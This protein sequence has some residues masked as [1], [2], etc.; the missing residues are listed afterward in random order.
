M[1]RER[2]RNEIL[3]RQRTMKRF[4]T[5]ARSSRRNFY[6]ILKEAHQDGATPTEL[7]KLIKLSVQRA[8]QIVYEKEDE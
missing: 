5:I 8:E 2:H 6:K 7:A 4:E 3:K 1:I